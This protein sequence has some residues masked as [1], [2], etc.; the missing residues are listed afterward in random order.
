MVGSD[1]SEFITSNFK[2]MK[3]AR[4]KLLEKLLVDHSTLIIEG[5]IKETL[6]IDYIL[7]FQLDISSDHLQML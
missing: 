4:M 3:D 7:R 1:I 5:N 2:I 6:A